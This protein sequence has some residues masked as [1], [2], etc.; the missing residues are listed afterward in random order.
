MSIK[1]VDRTVFSAS[2]HSDSDQVFRSLFFLQR[3]G[4]Y[5]T[6]TISWRE[7]EVPS[8]FPFHVGCKRSEATR[9]YK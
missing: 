5:M 7:S 3:I 1:Q 4:S 2:R 8:F 6:S 9:C